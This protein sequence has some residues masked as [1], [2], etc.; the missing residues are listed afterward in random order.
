MQKRFFFSAEK[1]LFNFYIFFQI[2]FLHFLFLRKKSECNR[3]DVCK[4]S[5]CDKNV[6]IH[7]Y[8]IHRHFKKGEFFL[9][10]FIGISRR[11]R[12][13]W[14]ILFWSSLL[15]SFPTKSWRK[16]YFE[17]IFSHFKKKFR[18]FF[19][20]NFEMWLLHACCYPSMQDFLDALR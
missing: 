9:I 20:K 7:F 4:T 1:I 2:Y 10:F 17:E 12:R 3:A 13:Y 11:E 16:K 15:D 14:N 8:W 6:V 18:E 5:I 19:R